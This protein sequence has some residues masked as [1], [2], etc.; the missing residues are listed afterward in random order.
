MKEVDV[1][2]APR[3]LWLQFLCFSTRKRDRGTETKPGSTGPSREVLP[4]PARHA[5]IR[6]KAAPS[7]PL[8]PR[9]G[10]G[11]GLPGPVWGSPRPGAH[12]CS[13]FVRG[14]AEGGQVWAEARQTESYR[15]CYPTPVLS[16]SDPRKG[17]GPGS[18]PRAPCHQDTASPA[19]NTHTHT[20]CLKE[21]TP[22]CGWV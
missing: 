12:L 9:A 13:L 20:D 22:V 3:P 11:G 21:G 15:V 8:S 7:S 2:F 19:P 16:G 17:L 4:L 5:S 10:F 6:G 14:V 18:E 1:A